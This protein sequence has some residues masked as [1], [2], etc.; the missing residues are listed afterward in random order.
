MIRYR[1]RDITRLSPS[2]PCLRRTHVGIAHHRPQRRH[3]DHPRRQR[4]PLADRGGAGRAARASRRTTSSSSQRHGKL[5]QVSVEVEA[6]PGVAAETYEVV[7]HE[8]TH[9]IKSM[10]GISTEVSVKQ[11]GAIPRSQGKAVRVRDLRPKAAPAGPNSRPPEAGHRLDS[12]VA[13]AAIHEHHA[14]PRRAPCQR[15]SSASS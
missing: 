10:V 1:T 4:V 9:H 13:G 5:D 11:P 15:R 14:A 3:A 6:L 2:V 7:A 8:V 12:L